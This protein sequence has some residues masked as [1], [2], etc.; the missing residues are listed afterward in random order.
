MMSK[1]SILK[2]IQEVYNGPGVD[3]W[4][5]NC[6]LCFSVFPQ[7]AVIKKKA[8]VHWWVGEGFLSDTSAEDKGNNLF[9]EF[10]ASG[11]IERVPKKRRPSSELCKMHPLIRYAVIRLAETNNFTR[12]HPNGNPTADFSDK[13]NKRGFLVKTEEG[14]S[15]LRELTYGFR[16]KVEKVETLFNVS[17]PYVDLREDSL[18]EMKNLKVL[19]LGRYQESTKQVVEVDDTEFLNDLQKMKHLRYFSLRGITRVTVLPKSICKLTKLIIVDL[20]ACHYLESLPEGIGSLTNLTWLDI[21]GCHLI[22]HMPAGLAKLSKLQVL[23]GFLIGKP[24]KGKTT[25]P[26]DQKVCKLEDLANLANLKKLSLNVDVRCKDKALQAEELKSLSKFQN[27]VSLSVEWSEKEQRIEEGNST[28][29]TTTSPGS[30][31]LAKLELRNLPYSE[32]PDWVKRLNLKN[33]KKLYVRGGKLSQVLR[34][35][36]CEKWKVSILRLELLSELQMDWQQLLALF[37]ELTYVKKVKCPKLILFP[38]DENGEWASG[39]EADTEHA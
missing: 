8:L 12:F 17:E 26:D 22:S 3:K 24:P 4:K 18:S 13:K 39:R 36:G 5:H 16:L 2:E 27:L 38:C 30:S 21:S 11:I 33:L 37:P 34:P 25:V 31:S 10:I 6:L 9:E 32:M 29:T 28:N 35:V 23:H 1:S 15:S 7:N 14:Y 19:Q 20:H